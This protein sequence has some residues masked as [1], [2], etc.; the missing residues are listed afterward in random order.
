MERVC[1]RLDRSAL[2]SVVLV[3]NL[4]SALAGRGGGRGSMIDCCLPTSRARG[5]SSN[6]NRGCCCFVV[7]L[8][9]SVPRPVFMTTKKRKRKADTFTYQ[10]EEMNE[11]TNGRQA[12][13]KQQICSSDRQA[14]REDS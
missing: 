13:G 3:G 10:E 4:K 14:Q 12:G 5:S 7:V 9:L 1:L 8:L 2:L 11:Q 6:S